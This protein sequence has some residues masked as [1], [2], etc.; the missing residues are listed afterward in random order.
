MPVSLL[1]LPEV[2]EIK[3]PVDIGFPASKKQTI[4]PVKK[5]KK[6]GQEDVPMKK[7]KVDESNKSGGVLKDS[8]G[9]WA[10]VKVPANVAA[11]HSY[12]P[13]LPGDKLAPLENQLPPSESLKDPMSGKKRAPLENQLPPSET[14]KDPMSGKKKEN[15]ANHGQSFSKQSSITSHTIHQFKP[16]STSVAKFQVPEVVKLHQKN[17]GKFRN[18]LPKKIKHRVCCLCMK[19]YPSKASRNPGGLSPY[20]HVITSECP[21]VRANCATIVAKSTC[22][23]CFLYF[24]SNKTINEDVVTHLEEANHD[25]ICF[26]CRAVM[27]FS[28]M[29]DHLIQKFYSYYESGTACSRCDGIFYTCLSWVNHIKTEHHILVPNLAHYNRFL[30]IVQKDMQIREAMLFSALHVNASS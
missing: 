5:P 11:M 22:Y 4:V 24:E 2:K 9:K 10:N 18:K 6:F 16:A 12:L 1:A 17:V 29:Y 7:Q 8:N 13:P 26:L 28:E 25:V 27:P 19:V 3:S 20:L 21:F 30:P 14:L 15:R 23:G